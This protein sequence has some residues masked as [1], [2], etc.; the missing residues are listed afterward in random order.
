MGALASGTAAAVG[1]GAFSA[2]QIRGRDANINVSGDGDALIQLIPGYQHTDGEGTVGDHRVYHDDD[3]QLEISFDDEQGGTGVNRN[4]TYQVGAI[5]ENVASFLND[6]P[7]AGASPELSFDDVLYGAGASNTNNSVRD[8]P[9]FVVRNAS[10][11]EIDIQ[12][13]Y[14]D[15]ESPDDSTGALI[16][17]GPGANTGGGAQLAG[18]PFNDDVNT[19]FETTAFGLDPGQYAAASLI[20]KVG[21]A[22]VSE[23]GWKGTLELRAE[24]AV[25]QN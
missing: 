25:L 12:L 8:D 16:L 17:V 14:N 15:E 20:V 24:E 13:S 2:A 9:A 4:S 5:G 21:D 22:D 19:D 11:Q 18:T 7:F 3:E 6:E 1:T 23:P 10:D